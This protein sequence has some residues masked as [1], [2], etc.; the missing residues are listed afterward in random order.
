MAETLAE[1]ANAPDFHGA[2]CADAAERELFDQATASPEAR[3]SALALCSGCPALVACRTWL[4]D[5]PRHRRRGGVVAG[6]VIGRRP[7][8]ASAASR[9]GGGERQATRRKIA[10]SSA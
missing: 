5:V 8:V 1:L 6:R 7:T 10:L 9:Q 3:E 4:E 2:A